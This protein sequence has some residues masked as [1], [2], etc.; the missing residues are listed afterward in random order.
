MTPRTPSPELYDLIFKAAEMRAAGLSWAS[1]GRELGRDESTCRNWQVTY[2]L[3]WR[4]IMAA[5]ERH[6][7]L[8]GAAEARAILR[9]LMRDTKDKEKQ[10]D[11][12]KLLLADRPKPRPTSRKPT[13]GASRAE[14]ALAE[15]R[16]M[17]N[18]ELEQ[19]IHDFLATRAKLPGDKRAPGDR[20]P[21]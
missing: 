10:L 3:H 21:E 2:R 1:I 4:R 6:A 7:V 11:A 18:E 9:L 19:Q 20:E 14:A 17:S 5:V 8:E 15:M 16:S 12:A 13:S